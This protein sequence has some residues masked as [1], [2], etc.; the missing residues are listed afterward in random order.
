MSN[1]FLFLHSNVSNNYFPYISISKIVSTFKIVL[2][3]H[4]IK[5]TK[6]TREETIAIIKDT[7]FGLAIFLSRCTSK[8]AGGRVQQGPQLGPA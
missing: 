1:I 5:E 7:L 8:I 3:K 4:K 6:S 2:T